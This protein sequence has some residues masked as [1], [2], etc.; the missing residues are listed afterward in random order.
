[1]VLRKGAMAFFASF[2][3]C[4]RPAP[5]PAAS[6]P[7]RT[8]ATTMAPFVYRSP[9][10]N[11]L[12]T[13]SVITTI[14]SSKGSDNTHVGSMT[15]PPVEQFSVVLPV[16]EELGSRIGARQQRTGGANLGEC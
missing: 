5:P 12:F 16:I 1:M 2:L 6:H 10:L 7:R 15:T 4:M 13:L 8:T 3:V 14:Q 9:C 11:I